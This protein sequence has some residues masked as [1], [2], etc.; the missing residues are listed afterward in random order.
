MIYDITH[1]TRIRYDAIV[2]FARF[3]LRLK[4]VEWPGQ[5]LENYT[6]TITPEPS[7][8]TP[9]PSVFPVNVLRVEVDEPMNEFVIDSRFTMEVTSVLPAP[10]PDDPTLAQIAAQAASLPSL[11]QDA[12]ANYLFGSTLAPILPEIA[13]WAAPML[14]GSRGALDAALNLAKEI[15]RQFKYDPDATEADTPVAEAFAGRHGVCQDFAH[16]AIVA[17][18]SAGLPAAY[19]SGFLRTIPPPGKE[20]LV[21]ADATH[22]WALLW[23]GPDLGWIGL[24]PTNAC[25]A[26]PDH[27]YT[28]MGRDYADVAPVDGL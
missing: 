13:A 22:A 16:V 25:L 5:R 26:G 3:N 11:S 24:D 10:S 28:A 2:N 21:G 9:K 6:L 15:H 19:A 20:R 4:P 27:I 17:L 12:P 14:A 23:C 18:R 1:T 8:F 7:E